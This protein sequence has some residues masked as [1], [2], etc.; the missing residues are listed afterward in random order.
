M[1]ATSLQQMI[2]QAMRQHQAGEIDEAKALYLKALELQ[3]ANPDA[4]HLCGLVCHQLGDYKSAI[5]Y[6]RQAVDHVPEQPVLRNNLGNALRKAGDFK[7]AIDQLQRA[8]E[9]RPGYA[10]AHLNLSL[11]FTGLNDHDAALKHG[12]EAV[13]LDPQQAEAWFN[14][15]IY[16][17]DHMMS[18]DSLRA[19]RT[20]LAIR[21]GYREAAQQLLYGLNLLPGADPFDIAE[22]HRRVMTAQFGSAPPAPMVSLQNERIRIGYVSGDFC[23][24]AVIYFFEPLLEHHDKASFETYCYS[25]VMRPDSVTQRLQQLSGHWRD[26]SH[27]SDEAVDEQIRSDGIDI[28]VDL[29]GHTGNNRLG[30]FARRPAR[31]QFSYL[32]YPNTTGLAAMDYRVVD[33]YTVPECTTPT[34]TEKL[35]RLP[36]IFACFRPPVSAPPIRN[37]P[38][39]VK[40][41]ITFGSLHR[42]EKLNASV[43]ELWARLLQENPGSR[44]LLARDELDDWHQGRLKKM[45]NEF[46]IGEE[47]LEMI[48]LVEWQGSFY[49]LISSMDIMLDVFPWSGHTLACCAL[50]MGVPV[51]TMQGNTHASRMVASVL[52]V[53]GLNEFIAN[54]GESYVRIA[55]NLSHNHGQLRKLRAE[56]RSRI[57]QS[58]L[59]DEAGFTK[60]FES[61]CRKVLL[62]C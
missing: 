32:G 57:K 33:E 55:S 20:A 52:A 60:T 26:I 2:K 51:V 25:N 16:F 17:H 3:P 36:D 47:R 46:G 50:W 38:V 4:L 11:A 5:H 30:V 49:Q 13:R 48:H 29:A 34:G 24:H 37:A 23:S 27:L 62:A 42:L 9:L 18:S 59:S 28:L 41:F 22:E 19:Y 58:P 15:G 10:G 21:P 39:E 54:D 31:C 44:L 8:L 56:L 43:I 61:A 35:L 1:D 14:L 40:G 45:F 6:I 53:L 7:G 12:R